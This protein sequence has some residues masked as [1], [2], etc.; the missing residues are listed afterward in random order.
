M[1]AP[2]PG[3]IGTHRS[4]D[5][6]FVL[7]NRGVSTEL[8]PCQEPPHW[9]WSP[10]GSPGTPPLAP[11]EQQR[12]HSTR[13]GDMQLP[14][15]ILC[16]SPS[17]LSLP[18]WLPPNPWDCPSGVWWSRGGLLSPT[19]TLLRVLLAA[20]GSADTQAAVHILLLTLPAR[21]VQ[22]LALRRGRRALSPPAKAG[23]RPHCTTARTACSQPAAWHGSARLGPTGPPPSRHA[24]ASRDKAAGASPRPAR[25]RRL[26]PPLGPSLAHRGRPAAAT[27]K[28]AAQRQGRAGGFA[29]PGPTPPWAGRARGDLHGP[30]SPAPPGPR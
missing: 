21:S 27:W 4:Q 30:G 10:P 17:L 6:L 16:P 8:S 13:S 25:G 26:L 9:E 28:S 23:V 3:W 5:H 7:S 1:P 15:P 24:P 29:T 11:Q 18:L 12:P 19:H 20:G 14:S 2:E 22:S